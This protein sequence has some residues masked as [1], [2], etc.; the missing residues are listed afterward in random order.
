[1]NIMYVNTKVVPQSKYSTQHTQKV[2]VKQKE[3]ETRHSV[4][5]GVRRSVI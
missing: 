5:Q 3:R 2:R 4:F 1:M